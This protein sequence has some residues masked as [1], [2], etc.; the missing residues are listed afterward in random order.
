[1]IDQMIAESRDGTPLMR[2]GVLPALE[3]SSEDPGA[4][5]SYITEHG[6]HS[7]YHL[8]FALR[9]QAPDHY[10]ALPA[11][12]RAQVLT[13]ALSHLNA[14]NDWGY[15]DPGG[16][17]DGE[18]AQAL[19]E[20]KDSAL[21]A[22]IPLLDDAREAFLF[23]SET[24]TLSITYQYR[25]KDFA[26]RYLCLIRGSQPQFDADPRVRDRAIAELQSALVRDLGGED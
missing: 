22:L 11:A 19:L 14:L 15:L 12:L 26:Y 3:L 5:A 2:S 8:L 16:S 9:R 24:A 7:A 20:L 25:R 4:I 18:A 23:G 1:M 21:E 13:A 10:H 6:D 17:H